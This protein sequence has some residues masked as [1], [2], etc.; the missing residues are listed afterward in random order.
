MAR[1]A[2]AQK[3]HAALRSPPFEVSGSFSI[4]E[5]YLPQVRCHRALERR[6]RMS[7]EHGTW[8]R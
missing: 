1:Q 3:G 5:D 6:L 4:G 8:K 7:Y 2:G